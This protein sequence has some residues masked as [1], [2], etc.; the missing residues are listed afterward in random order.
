MKMS[1][2]FAFKASFGHL[3]DVLTRCIACLGKTSLKCL[4]ADW[5]DGNYLITRI[6]FGN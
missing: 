4:F 3:Q 5:D 6:T 2:R 1:F